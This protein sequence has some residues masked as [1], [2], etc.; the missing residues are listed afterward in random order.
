MIIFSYFRTGR[1]DYQNGSTADEKN[2]V[3]ERQSV[4]GL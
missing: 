2:V 1:F 3:L 4:C